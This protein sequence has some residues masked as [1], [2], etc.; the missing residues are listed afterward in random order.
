MEPILFY[1]VPMGCSFGSIVALEWLGRPYRLC[2]INM[3]DD[4]QG[5]LY[6]RVNPVRETPAMLLDDGTCLSE[7]AAI[8]Q[9]IAARD[10]TRALG[11]PQGTANH[12]RLNQ[13]LSFL[14]TTFFSSF[15]PL[16]TAYEMEQNPP[17]QNMLRRLGREQVAKAHTQLDDF[18]GDK[19]WLVGDAPT[20]ADAYLTGIARWTPYH[21]AVDQRRFANLHRHVAKLASDPAV[22]FANAVEAQGLAS[23]RGGFRGHVMLDDL[24]IRLRA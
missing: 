22:V 11:F 2:R 23:S 24:R 15:N 7:S 4:M 21:D 9:H 14:T 16:W 5:D 1:G 6:A 3:P 19:E 20:I 8:L 17:V 13:V 12:D 18:I 10:L